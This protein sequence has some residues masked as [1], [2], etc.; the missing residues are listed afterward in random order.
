MYYV[1]V[2]HIAIENGESIYKELLYN[3]TSHTNTQHV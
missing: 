1:V 2:K 3:A